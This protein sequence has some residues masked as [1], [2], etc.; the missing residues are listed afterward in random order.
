MAHRGHRETS[1]QQGSSGCHHALRCSLEAPVASGGAAGGLGRPQ[2][3]TTLSLRAALHSLKETDFNSKKA[4]KETLCKSERIK[5]LINARATEVVN[6]APSKLIFT[7]LVSVGVQED[8]LT[9]RVAQDR[10]LLTPT[11]HG[12][13]LKTGEA[14]SP[15]LFSSSHVLRQ[16][17]FPPEEEPVTRRSPSSC[18]LRSSFDL[19]RRQRC[20]ETTS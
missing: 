2:L 12:P 7:S 15:F 9:S 14:P 4:V 13:D 18:P 8:E 20:W 1:S 11:I 3:H 19:H 16:K 17:P 6:V 10:L 5:S